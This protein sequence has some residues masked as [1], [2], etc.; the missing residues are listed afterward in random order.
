D[1]RA[2][3]LT[4]TDPAL[5]ADAADPRFRGG[6]FG[7][8]REGERLDLRAAA[9][10]WRRGQEEAEAIV[11]SLP[12]DRWVEVRY[13]TLCREPDAT[14]AAVFSLLG[15]DPLRARTD[16][17]MAARHVIGNGMRLDSTNEIRADDR[18]T[19]A[20]SDRERRL[21]HTVAGSM[22]RRLGYGA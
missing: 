4:Y 17:R 18:W 14:L 11:R 1:G 7:K 9:R 15:V 21:F 3:A 5:F 12:A 10:Q 22:N 8:S 2:V 13:E 19:S 16:F 6:G 20:L